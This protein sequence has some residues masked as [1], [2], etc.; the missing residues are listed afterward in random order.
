MEGRWKGGGTTERW[1]REEGREAAAR[2][3]LL[4]NNGSTVYKSTGYK[5]IGKIHVKRRI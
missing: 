2:L 3:S 5:T 4:R 1:R